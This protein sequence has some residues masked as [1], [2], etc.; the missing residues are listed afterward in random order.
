[1]LFAAVALLGCDARGLRQSSPDSAQEANS[2]RRVDNDRL[3]VDTDEYGSRRG[4]RTQR[5]IEEGMKVEEL[6]Y[7]QR[8]G[9]PLPGDLE[10]YERVQVKFVIQG[11]AG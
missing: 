8:H 11:D 5:Q 9:L 1:M 3:T 7:R 4:R 10:L 6:Q 2:Q